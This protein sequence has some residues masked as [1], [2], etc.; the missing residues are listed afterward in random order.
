[1][2]TKERWLIIVM[3]SITTIGSFLAVTVPAFFGI[4]LKAEAV[5]Y[6]QNVGFTA[7]GALI[8]VLKTGAS[9]EA[10]K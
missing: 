9:N 5:T 8:A 3:L 10:T 2:D 7:L 1:M 4:N 6:L